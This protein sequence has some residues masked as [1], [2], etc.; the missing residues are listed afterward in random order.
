MPSDVKPA[1]SI[2][3]LVVLKS[4]PVVGQHSVRLVLMTP[5]G[6]PQGTP[7]EQ[8]VRLL[9]Q[10]QGQNFIVNFVVGVH[11]EGLYWI[12]VW[13]DDMELTRI[14]LT[15]VQARESPEPT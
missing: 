9:G 4:G 11:E 6:K 5:S 8:P 12:H 3:C 15:V 10:D 7:V 2:A 13:F 1:F 14:P